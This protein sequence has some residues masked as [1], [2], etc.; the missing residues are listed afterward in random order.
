MKT[1]LLP[2]FRTLRLLLLPLCLWAAS[3]SAQE[4][5]LRPEEWRAVGAECLPDGTIQGTH[6]KLNYGGILKSV[7]MDLDKAPILVLEIEKPSAG[8][9]VILSN[10]Q[11]EKGKKHLQIDT[12]KEGLIEL[13]VAKITGLTGTQECTLNLGVVRIGSPDPVKGVSMVCKGLRMATRSD[14]RPPLERKTFPE[15]AAAPVS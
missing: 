5:S 3:L 13:D 4:I 8:W 10:P 11:L 2:S 9:Y 7:T 1:Q 12:T 6:D 14:T 15:L